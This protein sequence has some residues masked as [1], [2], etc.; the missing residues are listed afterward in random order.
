MQEDDRPVVSGVNI[1]HVPQTLKPKE[2]KIFMDD[3][4]E[5]NTDITT[6]PG[7]IVI[8]SPYDMTYTLEEN[9]GNFSLKL[10]G[11]MAREKWA[12]LSDADDLRNFAFQLEKN[13]KNLK[14]E[15]DLALSVKRFDED[16]ENY[17]FVSAYFASNQ[18]V[19][20]MIAKM[21]LEKESTPNEE[22]I[23]EALF[24]DK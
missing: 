17:N 10:I 21:H 20:E 24:G 14:V 22:D 23:D 19:K 8:F 7:Q 5:S 11:Y 18:D 1:I 12:T 9:D 4:I 6:D 2:I 13:H 3:W 15:I 16:D